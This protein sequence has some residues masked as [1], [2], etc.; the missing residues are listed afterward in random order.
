[1]IG[2]SPWLPLEVSSRVRS[3]SFRDIVRSTSNVRYSLVCRHSLSGEGGSLFPLKTFPVRV[4]NFPVPRV[5]NFTRNALRM[6]RFSAEQRPDSTKFP[7]FSRIS[8][9]LAAETRSLQSPSTAT[10][11]QFFSLSQHFTQTV[12]KKR[13]FAPLSGGGFNSRK[14]RD[15]SLSARQGPSAVFSQVASFGGHTS[16]D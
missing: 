13:G 8:G 4:E 12:P 1:M 14:Q 15:A 16:E 2:I 6:L 10:K 9:N 11:S 5:G 3:G 7:V